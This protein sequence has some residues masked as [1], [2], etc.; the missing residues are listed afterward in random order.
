MKAMIEI[1]LSK[2]AKLCI[3]SDSFVPETVDGGPIS[4]CLGDLVLRI[5]TYTNS[6]SAQKTTIEKLSSAVEKL[7]E[8]AEKRKT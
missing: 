7:L 3:V 1:A 5:E 2:D 4:E 6:Q 8:I